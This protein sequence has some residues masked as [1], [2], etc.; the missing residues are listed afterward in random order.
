MVGVHYNDNVPF[1]TA[2]AMASS[3]VSNVSMPLILERGSALWMRIIRKFA[4]FYLG[5]GVP[6]YSPHT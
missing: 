4:L 1:L 6:S 5:K 2:N 3:L